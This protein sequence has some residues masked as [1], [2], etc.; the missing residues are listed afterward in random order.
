MQRYGALLV[1]WGI[2]AMGLGTPPRALAEPPDE[3]PDAASRFEGTWW[4]STGPPAPRPLI[5]TMTGSGS[6]LLEDSIDGGGHTFSGAAFS[7]TQG[8]W[9][10]TGGHEARAL[11]LRF[12]Y[13][14]DG[15]TSAVERV[16]LRLTLAEDSAR[17]EGTYQYEEM[18]C[19]LQVTPVPFT[20]PVCPDPT[21][22]PTEVL[23]GPAPVS[24]VR[25]PRGTPGEGADR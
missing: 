8:S 24:G 25:T 22:A 15:K 1:F 3:A 20:V 7:I 17:V 12:V 16:R 10:R 18:A 11:G 21:V 4:L 5:L 13:D 14:A 19:G 23:R 6:F 9:W 2:L